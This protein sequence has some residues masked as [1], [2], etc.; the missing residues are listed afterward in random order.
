MSPLTSSAR[1]LSRTRTGERAE[2][3]VRGRAAAHAR[4][5]VLWTLALAAAFAFRLGFGLLSEF[6]F[7]DET[8]IFLL[9]LRFHSTGAWP[10]FGPDIVW[11]HSQI[12]GALQALLVGVPMDLVAVPEAPVVLLSVLSFLAL[13]LLAWYI[14]RR[15]PD[16]P[17]WLVY[18]WVLTLPWTLHYGTHLINTSYILPAAIIFF[19]AFFEAHPRFGVRLISAPVA[20]FGMGA[21]VCW[22]MQ[23]HA[24]WP[25]LG[26][27][28]LAAL[29]GRRRHGAARLAG[30]ALAFAAGAAITGSLLAPT[31]WTYGLAAGSGGTA[32]NLRV[33]LVSPVAFVT[34]LARFFSFASL[35]VLQFIETNSAK[36]LLFFIHYFW[37]VPFGI[38]AWL[39]GVLQPLGMAVLWFRRR[40]PDPAWI[41]LRWL[42]LATAVLVYLSYFF[43]MEPPQA[44]AFYLGLPVAV[45]YAA[46]CWRFVDSPRAR[47]VAAIV[48]VAG[49]IFDAGVVAGRAPDRS[50]YKNR[51][52][53]AAAVRLRAPDVLA[54]RRPFSRDWD[55][56]TRQNLGPIGTGRA[57]DDLRIVKAGWRKGPWGM[58]LWRVTIRNQSATTAYRDF[59]YET[60]YR[61]R[62]GRVVDTRYEP[63][64]EILQP[65]QTITLTDVNDAFVDAE[66]ASAEMK[67]VGGEALVPLEFVLAR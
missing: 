19:V 38:V 52:L 16:L 50:L 65:G 60:T 51:A 64:R 32:R 35:E 59:L 15:L 57:V 33:H 4:P 27:F 13:C 36:R 7:E 63:L 9:G 26:P 44:R 18:G 47:R 67:I 61:D 6:F 58:T 56:T 39:A 25:L 20:F 66:F 31:F 10:Y 14:C 28:V 24:S 5:V 17:R 29:W 30:D 22:M 45:I 46:Y 23:I 42:V 54:H 43:V 3:P 8:Q 37:L 2:D 55:W 12:P 53:V 62:S 1:P 21:A 49:I 41:P 40:S 48:L 11:T 34:T